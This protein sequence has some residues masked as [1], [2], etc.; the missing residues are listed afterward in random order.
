MQWETPEEPCVPCSGA[1]P[2]RHPLVHARD[3]RYTATITC[4]DRGRLLSGH[5]AD[6]YADAFFGSMELD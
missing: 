2:V 6:T 1:R 3:C 5:L 4:D